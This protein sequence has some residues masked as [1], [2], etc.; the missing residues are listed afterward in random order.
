MNSLDALPAAGDGKVIL[1]GSLLEGRVELFVSDNGCGILPE[2]LP[3]IFEPFFTTKKAGQGTGLGLPIASNIV[4]EHGGSIKLS[5][6]NSSGTT[7]RIC[8]PL[9]PDKAVAP[10]VEVGIAV[11][12]RFVHEVTPPDSHR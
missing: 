2:H 10:D 12:E 6:N 11:S 5:N 3:H 9:F 7:V 1:G 8:L 4:Q